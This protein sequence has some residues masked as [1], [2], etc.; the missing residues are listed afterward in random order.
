MEPYIRELLK[1]PEAPIFM[2]AKQI[3]LREY[4]K[5]TEKETEEKYTTT[6]KHNY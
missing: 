1:K 2:A 3:H 5:R 4:M 6:Q